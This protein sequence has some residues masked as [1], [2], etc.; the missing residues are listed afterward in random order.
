ML[1]L[2]RR[3]V[4]AS[5]AWPQPRAWLRTVPC[6]APAALCIPLGLTTGLLTPTWH[7]L[8]D[9]GLVAKVGRGTPP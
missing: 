5:L 3:R 1:H 6:L 2:L 4:V 9:R 7:N 8:Q